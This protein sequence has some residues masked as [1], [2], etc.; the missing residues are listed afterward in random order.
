MELV[1]ENGFPTFPK[2]FFRI[3]C[4]RKPVCKN[5][6]KFQIFI[7]KF[8]SAII[9]FVLC[10]GCVSTPVIFQ[11]QLPIPLRQITIAL[12]L[13]FQLMEKLSGQTLFCF[14]DTGN[15]FGK[16]V[17]IFQHLNGRTPPAV[18]ISITHQNVRI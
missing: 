11:V 17:L 15:S 9:S 3:F 18:T 14:R 4:S 13:S 6:I 10:H 12:N 5:R 1:S 2:F 8:R 7:G 16:P